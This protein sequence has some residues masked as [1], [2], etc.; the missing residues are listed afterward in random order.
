MGFSLCLPVVLA[1][2]LLGK[3]CSNLFFMQR[4][5]STSQSEGQNNISEWQA[6][7]PPMPNPGA[8]GAVTTNVTHLVWT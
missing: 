7:S 4:C 5:Q 3:L 2:I 8:L 6:Q 1:G